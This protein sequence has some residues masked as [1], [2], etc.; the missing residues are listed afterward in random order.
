MR[1]LKV[2]IRGGST[3]RGGMARGSACG[4]GRRRR[5]GSMRR[6]IREGRELACEHASASCF[7]IACLEVLSGQLRKHGVSV[8]FSV[9]VRVG[10]LSTSIHCVFALQQRS[11]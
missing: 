1:S 4:E 10:R 9:Q 6:V 2:P 11:S 3:P 7:A 5:L 8:V